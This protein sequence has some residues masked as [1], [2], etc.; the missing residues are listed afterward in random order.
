MMLSQTRH[1]LPNDWIRLQL[2]NASVYVI[3]TLSRIL[4]LK[5]TDM[6]Q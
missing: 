4:A 2:L 3:A 5:H 1:I 6:R